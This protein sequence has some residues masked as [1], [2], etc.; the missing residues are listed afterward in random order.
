MHRRRIFSIS[1]LK[2]LKE[3]YQSEAFYLTMAIY[4]NQWNGLKSLPLIQTW[5]K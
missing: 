2:E 3:V 1:N 4:S 5:F